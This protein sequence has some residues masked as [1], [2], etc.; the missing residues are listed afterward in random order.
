MFQRLVY[1]IVCDDIENKQNYLELFHIIEDII[2]PLFDFKHINSI[3][4][5]NLASSFRKDIDTS[6]NFVFALRL[7]LGWIS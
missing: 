1:F 5:F 6:G 7:G 3:A 2:R 4:I